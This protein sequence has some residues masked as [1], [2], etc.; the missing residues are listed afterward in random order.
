MKLDLAVME[1]LSML[2]L[3]AA[4]SSDLLDYSASC[5][6]EFKIH[7]I[8]NTKEGQQSFQD[9]LRNA[10]EEL[11]TFIRYHYSNILGTAY[12]INSR[13]E[14]LSYLDIDEALLR[15]TVLFK[16]PDD[17]CRYLGSQLPLQD[18][19]TGESFAESDFLHR[20]CLA[21]DPEGNTSLET[22][23]I[24]A[25]QSTDIEKTRLKMKLQL[26]L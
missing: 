6:I 13:D 14:Y 5:V 15:D 24:S 8:Q 16:N 11:V 19:G 20:Y 26:P 12:I 18:G 2:L 9:K 7:A 4:A 17:L 1:K 23:E 25:A 10:L 3:P 22:P 21:R